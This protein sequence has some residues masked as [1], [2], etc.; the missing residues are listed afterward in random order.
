M[1]RH[2]AL[3]PLS[4]DHHETLILAQLLKKG[5]PAYRGL[6]EDLAGKIIYARS[7][8]SEKISAHFESEESI[9]EKLLDLHSD[10]LNELGEVV[11]TDH[12][13]LR[14]MFENLHRD[15]TAEDLDTLGKKLEAHVRMEE[16]VYFP[17]VEEL[18]PVALM[19]EISNVLK[20]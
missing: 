2:E 19:D 9:I 8:F 14:Q 1:K 6:P 3:Q 12:E 11:K 4:R 10:S 15:S 5:A 17:K 20:H 7:L 18:C 16:R 13:V